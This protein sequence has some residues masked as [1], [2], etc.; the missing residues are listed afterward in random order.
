MR[1]FTI[2]IIFI[3]CMASCTAEENKIRNNAPVSV[4]AA[5]ETPT[6]SAQDMDLIKSAASKV[7]PEIRGR[8]EAVHSEWYETAA[9]TPEI[10]MSSRMESRAELPE[11]VEL[12]NMGKDIIPLVIEKMADKEYFFT[13]LV[14]EGINNGGKP[15]TD[16]RSESAQQIA[17]E[18]VDKWVKDTRA[19]NSTK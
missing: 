4:P 8:F 19:Q 1:H 3:C 10:A 18:Y 12:V 5:S 17:K 2:A 15:N 6:T 16:T 13:L 11:Y 14:Y 9:K 7:D